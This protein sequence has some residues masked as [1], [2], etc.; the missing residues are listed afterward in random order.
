[1]QFIL[2]VFATRRQHVRPQQK[3][4]R[5]PSTRS[6]HSKGESGCV[7][8]SSKRV[9]HALPPAPLTLQMQMANVQNY[10]WQIKAHKMRKINNNMQYAG[11]VHSLFL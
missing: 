6:Q 11:F 2:K 1:M 10:I 5:Q 4:A 7:T 3:V 9:L 8:G